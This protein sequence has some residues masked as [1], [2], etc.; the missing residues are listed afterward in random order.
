MPTVYGA[1]NEAVVVARSGDG[2]R[3]TTDW[4][5]PADRIECLA[6]SP[7]APER[8]FL[9]TVGDGLRRSTD[10]GDSWETVARFGDRVTAVTVSPHD[11]DTVWAGTEPSRVF[12]STDG[13]DTW[14]ERTGLRDLPS[15]DRWS[16]PPRPHTHHV[17]WIEVAPDDPDRLY[18]AI[19]AG[20]FLRS[21]DG[22]ETWQDH[23]DSA[24]RDNH[25]IATHPDRPAHVYVAAGDGYAESPDGGDT[26]RYPE[27]G[28]DH[29]YVWGLAVARDDPEDVVVSGAV[30]ARAAHDP[31]GT[32][33]VYRRSGGEWQPAMTGL[34]GPDGWGR[35]LLAAAADGFYALSNQGLFRS[36][37]GASWVPT[38]IDWPDAQRQVL[39]RGVAVLS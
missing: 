21:D 32:S 25:A 37:D 8:V 34:P 30:G 1:M 5:R 19:E 20:A 4:Y 15:A 23:P 27:D 2:G 13:G 17:R 11:S 9:G 22:G 29:R 33:V 24:R 18:V 12:T 31:D 14:R 35:P 7:G 6:V 28:L 36:K 39:P 3:W 16:F 10:A 26:W 38:G